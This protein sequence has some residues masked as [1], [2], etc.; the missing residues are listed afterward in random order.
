MATKPRRDIGEIVAS[1]VKKLRKHRGWSQE[2]LA[3]RTGNAVSQ[4][5]ISAIERN[6]TYPATDTLQAI[7]WALGVELWQLQMEIT[8]DLLF[9]ETLPSLV[10]AFGELSAEDR[11]AIQVLAT[12]LRRPRPGA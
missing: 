11:D 8:D 3:E 9:T 12:R 6:E 5:M 7:A 4:T 1:A 10:D 2:H